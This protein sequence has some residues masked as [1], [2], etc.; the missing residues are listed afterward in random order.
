MPGVSRSLL[1]LHPSTEPLAADTEAEMKA[2]ART[3][4]AGAVTQPEECGTRASDSPVTLTDSAATGAEPDI[5]YPR[6][7]MPTQA[8]VPLPASRW[9]VRDTH[10][11]ADEETRGAPNI[12][13]KGKLRYV[14][15]QTPS[16]ST[17]S[18]ASP[19]AGSAAPNSTTPLS[20]W[21]AA[22]FADDASRRHA[23]VGSR[24]LRG[25]DS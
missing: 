19:S 14:V 15:E 2:A 12:K 7:G 3:V 10:T 8:S 23:L 5:E 20:P 16:P 13:D 4:L 18:N 17:T 21:P 9:K 22:S 24:A 1:L 6:G 25:T 11:K